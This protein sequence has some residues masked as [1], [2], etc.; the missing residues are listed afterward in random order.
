[1]RRGWKIIAGVGALV[2]VGMATGIIGV[3]AQ[4]GRQKLTRPSRAISPSS[5]RSSG[6]S[7]LG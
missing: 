7:S 6:R 1:M 4:G 2:I 3:Q 5:R